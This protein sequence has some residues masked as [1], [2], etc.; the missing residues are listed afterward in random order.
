MKTGLAD[1]S[2]P[3]GLAGTSTTDSGLYQALAAAATADIHKGGGMMARCCG[4]AE[5]K[6]PN[7]TRV[8]KLATPKYAHEAELSHGDT[9]SGGGQE[10]FKQGK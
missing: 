1:R 5:D 7:R 6:D 9:R 3:V 4:A 10:D 2:R 8:A